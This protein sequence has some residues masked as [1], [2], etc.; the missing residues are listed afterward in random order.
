MKKLR[1]QL[2]Q[3]T[4]KELT[5][6]CLGL[7]RAKFYAGDDKGFYQERND[8][9]RRVVLYPAAWLNERG[10]TIH[11][12]DY[13]Q[14]IHKVFIQASA[15]VTSKIKYRPAYLRQ[16]IQSHMAIHGE[17]Y[18]DAAK[19]TRNTI[20]QTMQLIGQIRP[21]EADPVRKLAEAAALLKAPVRKKKAVVKTTVKTQLNLFG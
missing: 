9:L 12:D 17:D 7:L 21:F 15:H 18:Y 13:R 6:S 19:A 10:V 4:P 8:L 20:E 2:K 5:D 16:V 3:P 11:G 14:I 1:P